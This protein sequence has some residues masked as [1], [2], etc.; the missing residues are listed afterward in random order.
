MKRIHLILF[1]LVSI[2]LLNSC[3][4]DDDP[5]LGFKD[6]PLSSQEFLTQYFPD[7]K[8]VSVSLNAPVSP[9]S[10][11]EGTSAEKAYIYAY[12]EGGICAAF[13]KSNGEWAEIQ[14]T[15]GL[16]LSATKI[17]DEY[18]YEKLTDKEPQAKILT[19]L[20]FYEE[21][22]IMTLDNGKMYAETRPLAYL[23][24]TLA[25]TNITDNKVVT[26]ITDFLTRNRIT[27]AN[28]VGAVFKLTEREGTAYRL[29]MGD[30]MAISFDENVDWI[31]AEINYYA[32]NS[33]I[34]NAERILGE[35][36]KNEIP[37]SITEAIGNQSDLGGIRIIAVYEDGNYG[38]RFQNKDFLVNKN[39]GIVPPP[40]KEADRLIS[41]YYDSSYKLSNPNG[42]T[43]VGAY[44]YN[45]TFIYDGKDNFVSIEV[46]M[47]G[48]WT[49]INA[50]YIESGKAVYVS[51]PSKVVEE[52]PAAIINYL[53]ANYKDKDIYS[54]M[55]NINEN[56][57]YSVYV[58][59]K[60]IVYFNEDGS[61]RTT[62]EFVENL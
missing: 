22:I 48:D 37:A 55:H 16:P 61:Y 18:V 47:K 17:L 28:M 31:H 41:R 20:P 8:L 54:L 30:V 9:R 29:I 2:V 12:L 60:Y 33:N 32:D 10:T 13:N 43:L 51:L 27:A 1:L 56:K 34:K 46:D 35:I 19:L 58:D 36:A 11:G 7:N 6:L 45:S 50:A 39:T 53:S 26:K 5:N 14:A 23:G 44:W 38:L 42:L 52:L 62:M 21:T 24:R 3:S 59:K 25:E 49:K 15:N 57:G 4:D 40:T